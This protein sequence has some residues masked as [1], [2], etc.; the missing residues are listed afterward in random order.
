MTIQV[1]SIKPEAVS[2]T[3]TERR[4]AYLA[5]LLAQRPQ[6][7]DTLTEIRDRALTLIQEQELPS[8][9]VEDWRFTDLAPLYKV[10]FCAASALT[11]QQ[12]QVTTVGWD[13][14]EHIAVLINGLFSADYSRPGSLASAITLAT[15]AS[16]SHETL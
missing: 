2:I 4:A 8:S 10:D 9:K 13:G 15:V 3:P 7:N 1:S 6:Q 16:L 14:I 11:L 5:Q 12:E